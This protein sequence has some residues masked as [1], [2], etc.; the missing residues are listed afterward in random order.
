[1]DSR[2]ALNTDISIR[3]FKDFY[4]LKEELIAFCR[5][6][7]LRQSGAKMEITQR[8]VHYL[9]TG[10]KD[11]PNQK[12]KRVVQSTF[13]WK[14]E[15]L[16]LETPITDSYKNTSNVRQ[17]FVQHI[18]KRFR[19]NLKFMDWMKVNTGKTLEDAI[20]VWKQ[21]EIEKKTRTA[22]KD[23][24]PQLE[25]N[26]YMRDFLADNPNASRETVIRYWKIKKSMRGDNV[27]RRSDLQL[28]E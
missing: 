11:L 3:D 5:Q 28:L 9:E 8:I 15:P 14:T 25:Y 18:G 20:Q 27:Y 1:M 2:P 26:R 22:P 19:F 24:P 21:I 6:E 12:V 4:W 13:D 7:G 16:S 23:I 10:N 17:F